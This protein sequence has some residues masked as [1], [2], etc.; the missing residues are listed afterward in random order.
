MKKYKDLKFI[1]P[2]RDCNLDIVAW[3][4]TNKTENAL[5]LQAVLGA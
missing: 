5:P 3:L 4:T 1:T 2:L